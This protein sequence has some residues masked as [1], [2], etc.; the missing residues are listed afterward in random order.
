MNPKEMLE[1]LRAIYSQIPD[2]QSPF[3]ST[4]KPRQA[5]QLRRIKE[6][7]SK[8]MLPVQFDVARMEREERN[9]SN[10]LDAFP[11][12]VEQREEIAFNDRV[13]ETSLAQEQ[14]E[15]MLTA[16]SPGPSVLAQ[17]G[18]DAPDSPHK[19]ADDRDLHFDT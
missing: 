12:T 4:L 16:A 1:F 14:L 5:K 11:L 2:P 7:A 10:Q 8:L 17:D 19:T 3:W 15:K 6:E 18:D 13:P 9:R